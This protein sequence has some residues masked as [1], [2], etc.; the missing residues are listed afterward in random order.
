MLVDP[1]FQRRGLGRRILGELE[2]R[3]VAL[4]FKWIKVDTT[5]I[6]VGSQRLYETAGYIRRGEGILHGY[7]VIFY[8]K[9]FADRDDGAT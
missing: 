4:G 9:C 6:Q 1:P 5:T 8:E 7:V 2:S 3:A